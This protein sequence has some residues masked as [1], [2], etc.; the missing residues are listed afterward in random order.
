MEHHIK[1][2]RSYDPE[3]KEN[4]LIG[5]TSFFAVFLMAIMVLLVGHRI[6]SFKKME[7]NPQA[8]IVQGLSESVS[9]GVNINN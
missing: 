9:A 1:R 6:D 2:I 3:K 8:N 4:I 7:K 5:V